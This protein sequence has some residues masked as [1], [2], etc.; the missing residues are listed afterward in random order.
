MGIGHNGADQQRQR[1][2]VGGKEKERERLCEC[3]RKKRRRAVKT[4]DV[5]CIFVHHSFV[6]DLKQSDA[7][8]VGYLTRHLLCI[9]TNRY[10]NTDTEYRY[11]YPVLSLVGGYDCKNPSNYVR[12]IDMDMLQI[13]WLKSMFSSSVSLLSFQH[14]LMQR[15]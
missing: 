8:I 6:K 14:W 9:Y 10:M 2:Q 3:K 4:E 5:K 11:K 7:V 12:G 1:W 13:L 15:S